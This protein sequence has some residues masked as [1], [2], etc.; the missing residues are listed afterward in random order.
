MLKLEKARNRDI[1]V[2]LRSKESRINRTFMIAFGA[3]LGLHLL[4]IMVFQIHQWISQ[5]ENIILPIRV[6]TDLSSSEEMD[7]SLMS[8]SEAEGKSLRYLLAPP[9]SFPQLPVM[10]ITSMEKNMAF[11]EEKAILR[12][13]F[14]SIEENWEHLAPLEKAKSETR[15]LIIN[16]TGGLADLALLDDG[17]RQKTSMPG[18]LGNSY[19]QYSAKYDVQVERKTG[20]IFWYQATHLPGI[21]SFQNQA[22][23]ILHAMRFQENPSFFV[24]AGEV[25][26]TFNMP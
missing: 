22:E 15:S 20:R 18:S 1:N 26:I 24:S 7:G 12:N 4:A 2:N 9:E 5:G 17:S 8:F 6:E 10:P 11:A 25:E 23:Q 14:L 21:P 19:R 3:A 13:P 16:V